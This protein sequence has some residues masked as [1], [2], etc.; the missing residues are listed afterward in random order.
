MNNGNVNLDEKG[1]FEQFFEYIR[2]IFKSDEQKYIE[3]ELEILQKLIN[4]NEICTEAKNIK[5]SSDRQIYI[6]KCI[7]NHLKEKNITKEDLLKYGGSFGL[8][9]YGKVE[10]AD[11]ASQNKETFLESFIDGGTTSVSS[12]FIENSNYNSKSNKYI[13]SDLPAEYSN[14]HFLIYKLKVL[15]DHKYSLKDLRDYSEKGDELADILEE[16]EERMNT[17][18][19]KKQFTQLQ[20]EQL[21]GNI[22]NLNQ[23]LLNSTKQDSFNEKLNEKNKELISNRESLKLFQN[24]L[25]SSLSELQIKQNELSSLSASLDKFKKLY[26]SSYSYCY[27]KSIFTKGLTDHCVEAERYSKEISRIDNLISTIKQDIKSLLTKIPKLRNDIS[28]TQKTIDNLNN[29][30]NTIQQQISNYVN[31]NNSTTIETFN[32]NYLFGYEFMNF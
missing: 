25:N 19:V 29:D 22:S 14:D 27:S 12:S 31:S 24:D 21:S 6:Y 30:I 32:S 26:Q 4:S 9:L 15:K 3:D 28:L 20:K 17:F 8:K 11:K 13:N 7:S 10:L 2:N 23:Q 16:A 5:S 1:F 18:N